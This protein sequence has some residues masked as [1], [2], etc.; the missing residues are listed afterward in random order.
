MSKTRENKL[1]DMLKRLE[2]GSMAQGQGTGYMSSG[3]GP[4]FPACPYCGG[5]MPGSGAEAHFVTSAIGHQP[6]CKLK[7]LLRG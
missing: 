3:P 4:W 1:E 7:E 6:D 2:W 5:L